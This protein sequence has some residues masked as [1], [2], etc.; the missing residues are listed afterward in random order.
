MRPTD[1]LEPELEI[2]SD[3]M[4]C[5]AAG[6]A[7]NL[8]GRVGGPSSLAM[9]SASDPRSP[10]LFSPTGG[11]ANTNGHTNGTKPLLNGASLTNGASSAAISNGAV[12]NGSGKAPVGVR[13]VK[14]VNIPGEMMYEDSSLRRED[15]VRL[16]IQSLKE[17]GY[18]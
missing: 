14:R 7:N 1:D 18:L 10:E 2:R 11:G 16:V 15:Y 8:D 4:P 9:T 13:S 17:V 3:T 5:S 12:A 6:V